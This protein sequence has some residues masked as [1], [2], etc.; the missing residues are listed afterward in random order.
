MHTCQSF[1]GVFW[2]ENIELT[3]TFHQLTAKAYEAWTMASK[4][5][6]PR[7][8]YREAMMNWEYV[9]ANSTSYRFHLEPT[10]LPGSSLPEK[11]V[12]SFTNSKSF[13]GSYKMHSGWLQRKQHLTFRRCV[14]H[15]TILSA[16]DLKSVT[17]DKGDN[18]PQLTL[19]AEHDLSHIWSYS[20][21]E[22]N[23]NPYYESLAIMEP[24]RYAFNRFALIVDCSRSHT[25]VDS[26]PITDAAVSITFNYKVCAVVPSHCWFY[27]CLVSESSGE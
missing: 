24:R 12:L 8:N 14:C 15:H 4:R 16:G 27:R 20:M 1:Q 7:F 9:R 17:I 23:L 5:E 18:T 3:T 22:Q 25:E 2:I 21:A 10:M 13:F 26:T 6:I 19:D 11:L